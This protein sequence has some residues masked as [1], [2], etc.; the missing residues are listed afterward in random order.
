MALSV[1]NCLKPVAV[2][3]GG[4]G[5]AD[6]TRIDRSRLARSDGGDDDGESRY[7]DAGGPCDRTV[8]V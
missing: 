8:H 6:F 4:D 2:D 7:R 3:D 5:A 1:L